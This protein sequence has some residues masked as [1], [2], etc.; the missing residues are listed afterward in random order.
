MNISGA[1]KEDL[2]LLAQLVNTVHAGEYTCN[3]KDLCAAADAIRFLQETAVKASKSYTDTLNAPEVPAAVAAAPAAPA[4]AAAAAPPTPTGS[5]LASTGV[6]L[7]GMGDVT[8]KA[9]H[10]GKPS[11]K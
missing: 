1:T 2:R 5:P 7:P 11:K 10:P 3:G 8:V 6:S 4:A 9:F